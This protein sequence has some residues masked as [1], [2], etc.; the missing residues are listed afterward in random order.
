LNFEFVSDFVFRI[1]DFAMLVGQKIGPFAVE[2]EL[3]SG[4]MGA[5][6][7]AKHAE[8]GQRVAIKVMAPG[9]GTSTTALA[10][11][12]RES[13]ILK[14]LK[15]PNI[16]RLVATGKLGGAPFYAM[17]YVSGE[18][19]DKVMQ[20]R[21]RI[22][23]E[24]LV[25]LGQQ[26]CAALQHAH[27]NSIIHRDLKPSN[28]MILPDGTVKLTDFGIAKDTDVTQLTAANSTVGT[29][30]YMSPE[31]CRGSRDLTH[32]SDLYSLGVMFYELVTGKKPFVAES[33]ME[34]FALHNSGTFERPARLVLE[35]PLWLDT[36]IC[37]LLEK[38]PDKRPLD[39]ETV[40]RALGQIKEKV[41]AQQSLG[42]ET[43]KRRR[44]DRLPGQATID[45]EDKEA[46]RTL[47]G[48][49]K[50]KKRVPIYRKV[51]F[52]GIL[53]AAALA[54]VAAVFYLTFIKPPD[55]DRLY[56]RAKDLMESKEP[57]DRREAREGPIKAFLRHHGKDA[58]AA[59]VQQWADQI[60]I[61]IRETQ[62]HNRRAG[63][64]A[65]EGEWEQLARNALDDE[66][67]GRLAEARKNWKDL[68]DKYRKS[69]FEDQQIWA[70]VGE[71]YLADIQQVEPYHKKLIN[72][73]RFENKKDAKEETKEETEPEKLAL[74]AVRCEM[75]KKPEL[76]REKWELLKK[77][78]NIPRL[79]FV[80]AAKR[81]RELRLLPTPE[82]AKKPTE[83]E[84]EKM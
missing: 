65:V 32:K 63:K 38:L 8:T 15:H 59:E 54:G 55:P 78:E 70:M 34:M 81:E 45:E 2:K 24:E 17:E 31:Q 42:L 10:R 74:E 3:G 71:K 57:Q 62:M 53:F 69:P 73:I 67:K 83:K 27:Q 48:K 52:K 68:V 30:A 16:V 6:Y 36:L 75:E 72:R 80:L 79:L 11:F 4:A 61:E 43:V 76:A 58:R 51:W 18:S 37:Q 14:Q 7:R 49:R 28:V 47:A 82:P 56:A 39:A 77:T 66:E 5:V 84:P 35:I 41:E 22:T 26:L 60:D 1:S 20:R 19:L 23:W 12:K 64:F 21:G 29:A 9:L 13:D 33:P 25:P 46:A 44:I 40:G 50:K